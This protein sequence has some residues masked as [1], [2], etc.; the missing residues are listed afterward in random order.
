MMAVVYPMKI[1]IMSTIS[2][3]IGTILSAYILRKE[4]KTRSKS[5]DI[6]FSTKQSQYYSIISMTC[7]LLY[8]MSKIGMQLPYLCHFSWA[9]VRISWVGQAI[10]MGFYQLDRLSYCFAQHRVYSSKGYPKWL[11]MVMN[12]FGVMLFVVLIILSIISYV[13]DIKHCGLRINGDWDWFYVSRANWQLVL[14]VPLVMLY[15][16]Y[17][18]WDLLTLIL[19][20]SKVYIMTFRKYQNEKK[21]YNRIMLILNRLLIFTILYQIFFLSQAIFEYFARVSTLAAQYESLMTQLYFCIGAIVSISWSLSMYLMQEHNTKSYKKFL[22][23]LDALKLD[24]I[25]CFCC[26]SWIKA[27]IARN[28]HPSVEGQ[29][30]KSDE[31]TGNTVTTGTTNTNTN[32]TINSLEL[33]PIAATNIDPSRFDITATHVIDDNNHQSQNVN[34]SLDPDRTTTSM[35]EKGEAKME[36]LE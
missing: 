35:L 5:V 21:V 11:F 9:I 32:E 33:E 19:Y 7:G 31:S 26:K 17:S 13:Y 28:R 34:V 22:Y 30:H 12:I 24:Y 16:L 23:L 4:Y 3:A 18:F 20:S 2:G 27:E 15:G 8:G 29:A 10:F 6:T 25:F 1:W 14:R 36:T